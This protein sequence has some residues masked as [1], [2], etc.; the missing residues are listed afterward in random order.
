[1]GATFCM[2]MI[3]PLDEPAQIARGLRRR[4]P[5]VLDALIERHQHRLYRYLLYLTGQPTLAEDLFQET[6]LRVLERG[7]QYD[8]RSAFVPWLLAIARHL[9]ADHWRRRAPSSL[10]PLRADAPEGPPVPSPEP[11]PF[12]RAVVDEGR[13]RVLD[14]IAALP[15]IHREVLTLRFLEDLTLEQIAA[16]VDVPLSTVKSRLYRALESA[17]QRWGEGR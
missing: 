13:A 1:M 14:V 7:R 12:E 8:G 16:V 17:R 2:A 15:A 4:D 10:E 6:W 5:A 11:S 9:V 3:D